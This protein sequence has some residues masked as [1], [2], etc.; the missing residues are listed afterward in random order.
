[1]RLHRKVHT[2]KADGT[3]T[4]LSLHFWVLLFCH[5]NIDRT[6]ER[7]TCEGK[8]VSLTFSCTD[9]CQKMSLAGDLGVRYPLLLVPAAHRVE[10]CLC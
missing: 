2:I 1:M 7:L 4:N 8:H 10:S 3:K 6:S 5:P 9:I